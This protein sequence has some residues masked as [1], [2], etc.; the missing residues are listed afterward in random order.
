[1]KR[2]LFLLAGLVCFRRSFTLPP[3]PM[4]G[5]FDNCYGTFIWADGDQ[6]VGG[7]KDDKKH[8]QGAYTWADRPELSE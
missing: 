1:M 6:Y 3:C 4:S 8:G 2:I 5:Y 7:W